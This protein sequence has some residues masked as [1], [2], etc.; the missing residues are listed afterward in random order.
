MCKVCF[1]T[2]KDKLELE[3]T[4]SVDFIGCLMTAV[5]TAIPVALQAFM[6]CLAGGGGGGKADYKPGDRER[7]K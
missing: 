4:P 2:A 1:E 6:T 5:M 3:F 7:C